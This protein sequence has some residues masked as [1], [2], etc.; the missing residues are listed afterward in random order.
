MVSVFSAFADTETLGTSVQT[1]SK[2]VTVVLGRRTENRNP[3]MPLSD[4]I[5][6]GKY[7]ANGTLFLY[8]S[9]DDEW[10]LII[11][12]ASRSESYVVSTSELIEG[13]NIG[14][15]EDFTIILSNS[16]GICYSGEV[17]LYE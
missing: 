4:V 6:N 12:S 14:Y 2:E 7:N 8:P 9:E 5:V 10:E 15:Y 1:S 17:I 13:V 11:M 16:N 3:R